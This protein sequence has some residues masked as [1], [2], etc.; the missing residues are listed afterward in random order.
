MTRTK[1]TVYAETLGEVYAGRAAAGGPFKIFAHFT[2]A[3]G[4]AAMDD[5]EVVAVLDGH[6]A[7]AVLG[8]IPA[9]LLDDDD[10]RAV[11]RVSALLRRLADGS[12]S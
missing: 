2:F 11:S 9:S 7:A 12:P 3:H 8:A 4:I 1:T 6:E 10:L 5:R